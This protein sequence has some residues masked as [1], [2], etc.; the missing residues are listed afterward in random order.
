MESH[1][2]RLAR[3]GLLGLVSGDG[4]E[5]LLV[6][7]GTTNSLGLDCVVGLEVSLLGM[8]LSRVLEGLVKTAVHTGQAGQQ[9]LRC[10]RRAQ[11]QQLTDLER[12]QGQCHRGEKPHSDQL[13]C[14]ASLRHHW[15]D[16][17]QA[18]QAKVMLT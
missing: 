16:Q 7:C 14:L 11:L 15:P 2:W 17:A 5:E 4:S 13:G 18:Y 8:R 9:R 12:V 6:S 1:L 10:W 3:A